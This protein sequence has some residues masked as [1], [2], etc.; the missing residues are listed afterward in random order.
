MRLL[1]ISLGLDVPKEEDVTLLSEKAPIINDLI[2]S[3]LR[4]KKLKELLKLGA[5]DEI[6]KELMDEFKISVPDVPITKLYFNKF[7]IQ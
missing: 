2:I 6:R 4:K 7:I 5:R 3:T 1:L